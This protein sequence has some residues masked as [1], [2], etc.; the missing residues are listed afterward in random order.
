MIFVYKHIGKHFITT[1]MIYVLFSSF[2]VDFIPTFNITKDLLLIAV[3]GGIVNGCANSLVLNANGCGGGM[4]FI[5]VYFGKIKHMSVWNYSFLFNVGIISISGLLF[6][7]DSALYSIIYQFVSTQ[8][9]KMFDSRF[10]RISF[11]IIT[12]KPEEVIEE[13]YI[14][15]NHSVTILDG[16][17]SYSHEN[18]K[19]L[20]TVVGE[21]EQRRLVEIISRIDPKAFINIMSSKKVVGNFHEKQYS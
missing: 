7:W 21:Y 18:K 1:S 17:G 20:Y 2:V 3:F 4:D 6:G 10:K 11:F 16:V 14:Q 5:T 8:V 13:I 15:L 9:I 19:V 12:E